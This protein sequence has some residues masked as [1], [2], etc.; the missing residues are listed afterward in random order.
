VRIVGEVVKF[1]DENL[2]Y[3]PENGISQQTYMDSQIEELDLN[4]RIWK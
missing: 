2:V 1:I 4:T 3:A